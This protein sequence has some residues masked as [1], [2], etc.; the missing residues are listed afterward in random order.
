[1]AR[2]ED[3]ID[4]AGIGLDKLQQV[5]SRAPGHGDNPVG[6]ADSAADPTIV[7]AARAGQRVRVAQEAQVMDGDHAP[8]RAPQ[9]RDEIGAVQHIRAYPEQLDRLRREPALAARAVEE[10][11]RYDSPVQRLRRRATRAVVL[12]GKR[13]REGDLLLAFTGAANRDPQ[14]F[15]EPDRLDL[16]RGDSGHLAFGHGIHFCVGAALTRLEAPIALN[17]LLRRFPLLRLA[18]GADIRWKSNITFR[19]LEALPLEVR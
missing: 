9:G 4:L 3:D 18:S 1:M 13:I 11:L 15:D 7:A 10:L 14:R 12:G 19:G 5:V 6:A 16:G 2:F 8:A 17:A